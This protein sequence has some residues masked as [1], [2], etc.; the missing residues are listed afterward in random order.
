MVNQKNGYIQLMHVRQGLIFIYWCGSIT[1]FA[2]QDL[3]SRMN[4]SQI[5]FFFCLFSGKKTLA[6]GERKSK[7]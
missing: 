7:I 5:T 4:M 1:C 6:H 2:G 3:A